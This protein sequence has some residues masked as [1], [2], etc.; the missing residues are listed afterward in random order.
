MSPACRHRL[1][2]HVQ[3]QARSRWP[4]ALA[5]GATECQCPVTGPPQPALS[6][7]VRVPLAL[8]AEAR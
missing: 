2:C 8:L 1:P 3:C 4:Q 6:A 7:T 5:G